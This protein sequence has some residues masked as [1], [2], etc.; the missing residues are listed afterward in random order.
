MNGFK[1]WIAR[2]PTEVGNFKVQLSL[3]S[4]EDAV[5][6]SSLQGGKTAVVSWTECTCIPVETLEGP[7]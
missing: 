4:T 3:P 1:M 6:Y 5:L 2:H 7:L